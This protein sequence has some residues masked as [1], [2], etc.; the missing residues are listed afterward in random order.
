MEE[1][2]CRA[3]SSYP[4]FMS[5]NVTF[6]EYLRRLRRAKAW[7]LQDLAQASGVSVT[8]L[9]RL[10]NDNAVPNAETVVKLATALGGDL[11]QMLRLSECLPT[12]ILDRLSRRAASSRGAVRRSASSDADP[13][14][15]GALV[16]D[17][18]PSLRNAL[19]ERFG[20]L[21]GDVDGVFNVLQELGTKEPSERAAILGFL[22]SR[23]K[24]DS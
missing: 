13:S 5:T 9:S 8:H 7:G 4:I 6:G 21:P 16:R 10:E 23:A 20:L 22:A 18:D 1:L 14:F 24:G 17:I 3:T 15:P 11:N 12:E 2:T 19:A